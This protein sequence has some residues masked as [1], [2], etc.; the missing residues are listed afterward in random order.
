MKKLIKRIIDKLISFQLIET[1]KTIK[2]QE[3]YFIYNEN[4]LQYFFHSYNNSCLTERSIEIPIVKYHI[5]K[6]TLGRVLEIGNVTKHYYDLFKIFTL[7]DTLDKYET[8]YDVINQDIKD[9]ST[10]EQ[11]GFIYSISTF[12]HMDS[13]GGRNS[14]HSPCTDQEFSSVAFSN[15]N[16]V[17]NNLL[18]K[19]GLFVLTF[20][21]N[22]CA[23]EIDESFYKKEYEKFNC[24]EFKTTI[25]KKVGELNWKQINLKSRITVKKTANKPTRAQYLC[26]FEIRK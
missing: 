15:I 10:K 12:E 17:I 13:D 22:Y 20:P 23:G 26:V 6:E 8:A 9:Y 7:K 3:K 24:S 18:K 1:I 19:D 21:L 2:L 25:Y 16:Y 5:E 14:D 4:K 11:Y